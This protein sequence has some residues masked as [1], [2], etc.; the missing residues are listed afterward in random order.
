MNTVDNDCICSAP[1]TAAP[2][3]AKKLKASCD[4]CAM[5]KVKCD[6]GQ[7]QC[8]RCIR[9]DVV[10]HYSESRRI[11][12]ARR[13]YGATG[14]GSKQVSAS[15]QETW[16]HQS[17]DE[18]PSATH[19]SSESPE[20]SMSV[21]EFDED[22]MMFGR[23]A[24]LTSNIPTSPSRRDIMK[25][26]GKDMVRQ[27]TSLD[28][29]AFLTS[30]FPDFMQGIC[31][32]QV[33]RMTEMEQNPQNNHKFFPLPDLTS[34]GDFTLCRDTDSIH[35]A[36]RDCME[37]ACT[38]IKTLHMPAEN[39][40]LSN[41]DAK[42]AEISRSIDSTLKTNRWARETMMQILACPCACN[43]NLLFLLVLIA[44]QLIGTYSALLKQQL[45]TPTP[46]LSASSM[47]D[48]VASS[49]E[50]RSSVFDVTMTIGGYVLDGE[51]RIKAITQVIRS[52]IEDTEELIDA[53]GSRSAESVAEEPVAMCWVG[54]VD[55]LRLCREKALQSA[56]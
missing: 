49:G 37:L 15:T 54:L 11:G 27:E 36:K 45:S 28:D 52:Q 17:V 9:N 56:A 16:N 22:A 1:Y 40:S 34:A 10:C 42:N 48:S 3:K 13:I 53:L 30:Q 6:R 18:R 29:M 25:Q 43:W 38:T 33:P 21:D 5:S 46:S 26:R 20:Y 19:D 41:D 7:P 2:R 32:D 44:R 50:T 24:D 51:A 31:L 39:C 8:L 23:E 47:K 12:K 35:N 55:S 14:P 4:F